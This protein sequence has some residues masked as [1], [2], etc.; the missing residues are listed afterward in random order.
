MNKEELIK[1]H[2]LEK[3]FKIKD[4]K[5]KYAVLVRNTRTGNVNKIKFGQ[6][7]AED[8]LIHKDKDRRRRFKERHKCSEKKDKLKPGW[9]SCN[10]SW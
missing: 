3:P 9:W 1:K 10:W 2:G 7:G 6:A 5:K 8:Y 4:S